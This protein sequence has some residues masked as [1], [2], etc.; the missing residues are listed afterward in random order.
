[1]QQPGPVTAPGAPGPAVAAGTAGGGAVRAWAVGQVL[2]AQ[3]LEAG[4]AGTAVLAVGT[5]RIH[6]HSQVPLHRGQTL[7]LQVAESDPHT[8]LRVLAGTTP[9][10]DSALA[11]R[12][13]RAAL[14]ASRPLGQALA[15]LQHLTTVPRPAAGGAPEVRAL[16]SDL[17][18]SLPT[19]TDASD[20][21]RL[22]A[23]VR[24]S[25]L[26]REAL[27]ARA[28]NGGGAGAPGAAP[29]A[30][31][32]APGADL[33]A[34]LG[35]VAEA[36]A[37]A[38]GR[39]G[40]DG[41]LLRQADAAVTGAVARIEANQAASVRASGGDTLLWQVDLPLS[42]ERGPS[43]LRLRIAREPRGGGADLA[44]SWTAELVMEPPGLEPV[45][46]RVS[47]SGGRVYT[48]FTSAGG[49]TLARLQAQA[50]LLETLLEA[51]DLHC[52]GVRC[53]R[54]PLPSDDAAATGGGLVS[55]RA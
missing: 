19:A 26:F 48:L 6:A 52:G 25:G 46:A 10:S 20:P 15:T 47:L 28:R 36:V 51:V 21:A 16:M 49:E 18:A 43:D 35:A 34:R 45:H 9:E 31:H 4:A 37:R 7:T 33:K 1:M 44:E 53:R 12:V 41:A 11:A 13:L 24:S 54:G 5:Q 8:V 50:P 23:M 40:G 30:G 55:E 42:G 14:P 38:A 32:A 27:Q 2:A 17:V 3:V 29:A 22:A 39:D